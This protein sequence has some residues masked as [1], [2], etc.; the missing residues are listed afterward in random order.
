MVE[1]HRR[2]ISPLLAPAYVL[3]A[4]SFL[5]LGPLDRRGQSWRIALAV[6]T[7]IVLQGLYLGAFNLSRQSGWGLAL[8]YFIPLF[9]IGT[10]LFLISNASENIRQRLFFARRPRPKRKPA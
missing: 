10:G 2:I 9:P 1:A 4:L 3:I 5:L 6:V 8:M 7:T